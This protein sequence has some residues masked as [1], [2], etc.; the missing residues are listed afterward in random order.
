LD[1]LRSP[2]SS[3]SKGD[4]ERSS[5]EDDG[6]ST[7][8]GGLPASGGISSSVLEGFVGFQSGGKGASSGI[9]G[10]F[11]GAGFGVVLSDLLLEKRPPGFGGAV[12]GV[13]EGNIVLP[14]PLGFS[15]VAGAF[16]LPPIPPNAELNPAPNIEPPDDG[17][18]SGASF[19]AES[20]GLNVLPSLNLPSKT[21]VTC[22]S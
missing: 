22:L 21:P 7:F 11:G 18:G 12:A 14:L 17:A 10:S 19:L 13:V 1:W 8:T 15:G 9:T 20:S 16:E 3:S 4:E 5:A 6:A 2:S